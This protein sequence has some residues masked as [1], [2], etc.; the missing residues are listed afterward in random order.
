MFGDAS[1]LRLIGRLYENSLWT[2]AAKF[3][4]PIPFEQNPLLLAGKLQ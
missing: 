4:D 2:K 3:F 1:V